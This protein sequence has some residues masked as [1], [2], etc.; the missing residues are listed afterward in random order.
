MNNK[1]VRNLGLVALG[2]VAAVAI[3]CGGASSHDDSAFGV[4]GSAGASTSGSVG[5]PDSFETNG[6]FRDVEVALGEKGV[7]N[8]APSIA[9]EPPR[10]AAADSVSSNAGGGTLAPGTN[11]SGALQSID[12]KIVQTA[13][14]QLQVKEVGVGFEEVGR[15]ATAA[16]GFI[17]SSS[18]SYSDFDKS[19]DQR[20]QTASI[21]IRVP[22]EGYASVLSQLRGLADTVDYE[23]SQASDVTEEFTDLQS[24]LRNLEATETQLLS[25]LAKATTITDILTV[26][27]RLNGVQG[28]IEY[29]KGRINLIDNLTDLATIT[30]H[31]RPV[32][33]APVSEPGDG[34]DLGNTISEAWDDSIAF[35]GSIAE[36]VLTVVVFAWWLPVIGIPAGLVAWGVG[37]NKPR[38][39]SAVD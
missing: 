16:G 27:D 39:A 23:E 17:A 11:P 29:V 10:T 30:V 12:R 26:Q 5:A 22:S 34:V 36:G 9:S 6:G 18:F 20:S 33:G 25:L 13:S 2:V 21:T 35:L 14:L 15:I 37:R 8:G 1:T 4:G 7:A 32:V 3:A 24:R 31:L 38:S 28:D 19:D